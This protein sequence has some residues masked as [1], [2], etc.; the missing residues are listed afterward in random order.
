MI[1]RV[2]RSRSLVLNLITQCNNW[3]FWKF[4]YLLRFF[5][6][7]QVSIAQWKEREKKV[8]CICVKDAKK[9]RVFCR[10]RTG[11]Q[12]YWQDHPMSITRHFCG[13]QSFLISPT[14][15]GVGLA[16]HWSRYTLYEIL[17]I[18]K[19]N[20]FSFTLE[21]KLCLKN[22]H[23]QRDLC[24]ERNINKNGEKHIVRQNIRVRLVIIR[25]KNTRHQLSC[26]YL[27]MENYKNFHW[28]SKYMAGL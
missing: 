12:G 16:F 6:A 2:K 9:L 20:P 14:T 11:V 5:F 1:Y 23:R 17:E 3:I 19:W 7:D 22:K 10:P 4:S 24:R 8:A 27:H 13:M 21:G 15:T 26:L 18:W 28:T 25:Q